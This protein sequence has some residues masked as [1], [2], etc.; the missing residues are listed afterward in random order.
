MAAASAAS[1]RLHHSILRH[2]RE[3]GLVATSAS[4]VGSLDALVAAW[5]RR[6]SDAMAHAVSRAR[7]EADIRVECERQL[8]L[9][10]QDTGISLEGRHEFTVL[11]GRIDSVYERVVIEYKNPSSPSEC[12]GEHSAT[13]G[14]KK[15]ISQVKSRFA[16]LASEYGHPLG[17][18][19][20][21][22]LDGRRFVFLR[23]R[24]GQWQVDPPVDVTR[25][26]AER[27]LWALFNLGRG[28]K[29][30][31]PDYLAEDFGSTSH[32]AQTGIRALYDAITATTHP[33]ALV[34]FGQWKVL[35]G[36]VCGYEVE[37]PSDRIVKLATS[38]DIPLDN[39]EPPALLFA[40]HTYYALFMKLLASE[41]ITFAHRLP[42]PLKKIQNAANSRKLR[43]ELEDLENGSVFR[44]FSIT[45]FLEGDLFAW[46][47]LTWSDAV[48]KTVRDMVSRLDSY[49]P[50][51][52]SED[53]VGSRDLL[54]QL[55]EQLL[56]KSVRHDLGEYYTPDWL[57]DHVLDQ[58]GYEGDPDERVLD[59]AC[60]SGTFLVLA[61]NRV[62]KHFEEAREQLQYGE[63]ELCHKIVANIVGFDLNPLAVMA[64]RTNYLIAIRDLIGHVDAIEI[65]V[66]LCDSILTPSEYG[67]LFTGG[68]G[69]V[70]EVRT[71]VGKF[72]IPLE[73]AEDREQLGQYA[74]QLE[75]CIKNNYP[76]EDFL[77]RCEDEGLC[78]SM[79][80]VHNDLYDK[81]RRLDRQNKNGIWARII[82]NSFAPLFVGEVDLVVGNPP[83]VVWDNLP[84]DYRDD[85]KP[86]WEEYGLFTLDANAARHG[87]AKKD[88]SMLMLYV[89]ADRYLRS[90]GKL[91]FV[92]TQTLFQTKGAGDGFRRFRIG[93]SGDWLGVLRVDDMVA[94]QPF[95]GASN[96]TS[97]VLIE[98]G[99]KTAYPVPYYRWKRVKGVGGRA[100]Y[101]VVQCEAQ[102]VRSD[103]TNS[104]WLVTPAGIGKDLR[105]LVKPAQYA[106]HAGAYSGGANGVYWLRI[107]SRAPG[108]ALV[109]QNLSETSHGDI[110]TVERNI[111]P[112]YVY[113]LL[114]W[115][116][117]A[118]FHAEPAD[119]ILMVQDIDARCGID[120]SAMRVS[121][122]KTYSYLKEF[123][124]SLRR[125][126]AYKRYQSAAP[127][128][129]M[130]DI[131]SYTLAPVK[132]VWRRM[133]KQIT[134]A[135]V[136]E[137]RDEYLGVRPVVPQETCTLIEAA[138]LE[139][140]HYLC[141][142]LNSAVVNT[143]V[144]S[145]SVRG[146]KGFGSPSMLD[147]VGIERFDPSNSGHALLSELSVEAH[148]QAAQGLS[149]DDC[150]SRIDKAAGAA[151][152]LTEEDV[153][154]LT[155]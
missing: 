8:A 14:S 87:G 63:A 83:W 43:S 132:V 48:E 5:G 134:A 112:N 99:K 44:A 139:E 145:N 24:N 16:D 126:A 15:V 32:L 20:G 21:V 66:Y 2:R 3:R 65:P 150:Q 54:K 28:G 68:H 1:A 9:I 98:K 128:Y 102:P 52:L 151:W 31:A 111:E 88:I 107:L 62:R 138:T 13:G 152:G 30:Y 136:T 135:V 81:L 77:A 69:N 94:F 103:K 73:V 118:R 89:A 100:A 133:D 50:G 125:R 146:G 71:S 90:A 122:P 108:G 144:Q 117:V 80:H 116:G 38:F 143:I 148:A 109:V 101:D 11:S 154:R 76:A 27:F 85:T 115:S 75:H 104:P 61:I 113:P 29:P 130:Y 97:T 23:Y 79:T 127:F 147:Y 82:R 35:Y 55:Y 4:S 140:A 110:P 60:G 37:E 7:T 22:G 149:L 56:P 26:T 41:L 78:V 121:C 39:L 95:E 142:M 10:Q 74:T 51:T 47:L 119:F 42:S 124:T 12:I 19:L 123:E 129:S 6:F 59:P 96:W 93:A 17:S 33:K 57:A 49:N 106:A 91:A 105:D 86:L 18:L 53:P 92:I 131:D 84:A 46:Y 34:F 36:E 64:A 141:A 58:A 70:R 153:A 25:Q 155:D 40:V 137:A 72:R 114:R 67:D 120:E 45:N